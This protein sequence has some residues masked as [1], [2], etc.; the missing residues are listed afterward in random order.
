M[1]DA[2]VQVEQRTSNGVTHE[3]FGM[4]AVLQQAVEA[5]DMATD[6]LRAAFGG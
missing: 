5:Q 2:G 6:R 1:R 3:F 4:S